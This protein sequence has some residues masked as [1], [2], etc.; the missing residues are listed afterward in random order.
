MPASGNESTAAADG[1]T[2]EYLSALTA[3][4]ARFSLYYVALGGIVLVSASLQV[5]RPTGGTYMIGALSASCSE[6]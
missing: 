1:L 6:G 3:F 5:R 4:M 2:G